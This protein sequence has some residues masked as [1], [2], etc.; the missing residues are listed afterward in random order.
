MQCSYGLVVDADDNTQTLNDMITVLYA[1]EN[2]ARMTFE[3]W[4]EDFSKHLGNPHIRYISYGS[5]GTCDDIHPE[6]PVGVE[7]IRYDS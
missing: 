3:K 1:L 5:G 4:L 2:N 6:T 7:N